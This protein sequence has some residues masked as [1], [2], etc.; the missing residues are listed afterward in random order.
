MSECNILVIV[1]AVFGAILY[2]LCWI[3]YIRAYP[4]TIYDTN[5]ASTILFCAISLIGTAF[6]IAAATLVI[7]IIRM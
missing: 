1:M 7:E 5:P 3:G 4:L 6:M 2:A